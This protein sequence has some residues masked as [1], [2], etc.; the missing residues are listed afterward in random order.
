MFGQDIQLKKC[1][2][3]FSFKETGKSLRI[4]KRITKAYSRKLFTQKISPVKQQG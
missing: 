2:N 3:I 4:N 1:E